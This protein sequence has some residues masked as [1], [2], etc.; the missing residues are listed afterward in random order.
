MDVEYLFG[1]ALICSVI[2]MLLAMLRYMLVYGRLRRRLKKNHPQQY[3]GSGLDTAGELA[4]PSAGTKAVQDF[5]LRRGYQR[6]PD[7]VVV[8]LGASLYRVVVAM[9]LLLLLAVICMMGGVFA[10]I[11]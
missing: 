8:A 6:H 4:G 5:L 2:L 10:R 3:F 7:P 11:G 1:V 9:G